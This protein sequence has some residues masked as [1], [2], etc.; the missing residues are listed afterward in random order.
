[1]IIAIDMGGTNIRVALVDGKQILKLLSR[2]TIVSDSEKDTIEQLYSMIEEINSP[3]VTGI[4]IGVPSV[5]DNECGIVYNVVAIPSWQEVPLKE[6]LEKRF[7]I[8]VFINNDCNCFALAISKYGEAQN[9]KDAVC[10]TLGTGVGCSLVID[11]KLYNG[12]NTGSGEIGN[13][14]YLDK[15]YEYYCSSRFFTEYGITGKDAALKA[16]S[17]DE[18]ALAV[19]STFGKHIGALVS[20]VINAYDP[21]IIVFG[22]SISTAYD[23][24]KGSMYEE[25]KK[26]P[27]QRSV[28]RLKIQN[29]ALTH[30]GILG[31]SLLCTQ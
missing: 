12:Y 1:M 9:C 22:G 17:N 8:P 15:N 27:V 28:K 4:G 26:F 25:L 11:G 24:F 5:V 23:F 6:L 14:P 19:W 3:E 31:A 20:L 18:K 13:I 16:E 29:T 30:P 7:S 10:I 2:P 21:E